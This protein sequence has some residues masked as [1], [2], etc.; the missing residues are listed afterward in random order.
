[1]ETAEFIYVIRPTRPAM[2]TDG[3][4]KAEEESVAA[5]FAYL[6]KL[7]SEGVVRLAGRT[8]ETGART[9]G[10]IVFTA[11]TLEAAQQLVDDDP[12]VARGV[13]MAELFPFRVAVG[14]G[15]PP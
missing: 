2:L 13:M 3:M 12:A 4:T 15:P 10:I 14:G 11:A 7:A 1:M 9:F 8:Q 6:Q 5:H